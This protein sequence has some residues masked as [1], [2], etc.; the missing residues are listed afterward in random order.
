MTKVDKARFRPSGS[1]QSSWGFNRS[2]NNYTTR[3]KEVN[4]LIQI[5]QSLGLR[6][7]RLRAGE[8][9]TQAGLHEKDEHGA[10]L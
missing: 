2:V 10:G 3:E 9:G 5:R 1:S 6:K 4:I 8:G 7:C